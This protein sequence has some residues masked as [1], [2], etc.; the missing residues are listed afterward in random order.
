MA[1]DL[2]AIILMTKLERM[3]SPTGNSLIF[4][5]FPKNLVHTFRRNWS[6]SKFPQF[7]YSLEL[8]PGSI[9]SVEYFSL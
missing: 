3:S 5:T 7:R 4:V 8:T 9:K 6:T 1:K 2:E